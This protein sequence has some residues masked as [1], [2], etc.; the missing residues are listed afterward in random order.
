MKESARIFRLAVI[1]TLN[2]LIMA[3]TVWVMMD[4]LDINYMP[5]S[6]THLKTPNGCKSKQSVKRFLSITI[7]IVC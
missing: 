5:V 1:G 3:V 4:E 7:H 2:A 6:Y